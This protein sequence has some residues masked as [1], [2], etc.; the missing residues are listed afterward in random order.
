MLSPSKSATATTGHS[1]GSPIAIKELVD[2]SP[3]TN[4]IISSVSLL[5]TRSAFLSPVKS[6][7]PLMSNAGLMSAI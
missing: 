7:T 1:V 5:R 6:E 4:Q 3:S 2:V